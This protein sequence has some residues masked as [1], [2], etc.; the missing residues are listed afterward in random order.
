VTPTEI[1]QATP[2]RYF[3]TPTAL[4][5]EATSPLTGGPVVAL[6]TARTAIPWGPSN[7]LLCDVQTDVPQWIGALSVGTSPTDG[8]LQQVVLQGDRADVATAG[9]VKGIQVIDLPTARDLLTA[10][11]GGQFDRNPE[12]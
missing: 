8:I 10:R 2:R 12:Y 11:L 1:V 4:V 6:G 3:G 5:G 9:L 7:L